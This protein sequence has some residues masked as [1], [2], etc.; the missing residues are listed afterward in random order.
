[1]CLLI[2]LR[3]SVQERPATAVICDICGLAY[4][5]LLTDR[6]DMMLINC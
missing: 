2:L 5:V 6:R 3:D 1:M 4:Y